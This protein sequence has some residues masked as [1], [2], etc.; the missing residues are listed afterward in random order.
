M[1]DHR[2]VHLVGGPMD[3][4]EID[5]DADAVES[6]V[7]M[8]DNTRHLYRADTARSADAS[9]LRYVGRVGFT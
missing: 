9:S 5:A 3:G 8:A 1:E 2:R 4:Y 6:I 7:R